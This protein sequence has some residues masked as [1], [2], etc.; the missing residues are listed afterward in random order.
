MEQKYF[1][2]PTMYTVTIFHVQTIFAFDIHKN[3]YT[4]HS[5]F[6][7][8]IGRHSYTLWRHQRTMNF[9]CKQ[10]ASHWVE[11]THKGQ[12]LLR[13]FRWNENRVYLNN[14]KVIPRMAILIEVRIRMDKSAFAPKNRGVQ[15]VSVQ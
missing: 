7:F 15:F 6:L 2:P 11:H 5:L 13:K 9:E 10:Y 8:I 3:A 14:N 1:K 4:I 12:G